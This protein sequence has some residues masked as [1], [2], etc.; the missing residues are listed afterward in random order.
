MEFKKAS[1][2]FST[3]HSE[4]EHESHFRSMLTRDFGWRI[5]YDWPDGDAI[6]LES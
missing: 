3:V 5:D 4:L 2:A 6:A 1:I